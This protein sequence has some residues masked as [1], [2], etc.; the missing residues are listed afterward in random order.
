MAALYTSLVPEGALAEINHHWRQLT[1]LPTKPAMLHTLRVTT[2]R[3][4]RLLRT[5]LQGLGLDSPSLASAGYNQSQEIG[6]AVVFLGF[7][8]LIVPSA[9]WDCDNLVIY[10]DNHSIVECAL[11]VVDSKEVDWRAWGAAN[12]F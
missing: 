6:A 10:S 4:L 12:G 3:T 11:D 5:D 1:P 2:K 8:G 7:D 9:R